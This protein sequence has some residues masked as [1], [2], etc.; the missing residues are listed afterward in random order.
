MVST[1]EV[2]CLGEDIYD[3]F[4]KSI[5]SVGFKLPKKSILLSTGPIKD[6]AYLLEAVRKLYEMGFEL[7]G[8]KGTS[9]FLK[10]NGIESTVL[11]WPDEKKEPNTLTY[12]QEGKIDLVINIPKTLE[13][14]EL[15]NDY[16][17]RRKAVDFNVSLLT[18]AQ[19]AKLFVESI[20]KKKI[21]ELEIKS[22]EEY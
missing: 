7:Y 17:I 6:K 14:T 12:I 8:T 18:N 11:H 1:G 2:G 16:L 15:E 5:L 3:A 4:L 20:W 9:E 21:E 10:E 13:E 22:W 19:L